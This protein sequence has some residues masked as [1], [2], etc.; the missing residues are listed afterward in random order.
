MFEKKG[1]F[2]KLAEKIDRKL[3]EKS[4]KKCGCEGE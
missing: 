3:V 2:S 1:F 4:K